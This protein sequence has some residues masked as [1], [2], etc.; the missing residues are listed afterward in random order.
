MRMSR[1][2]NYYCQRT[3]EHV[4]S[5]DGHPIDAFVAEALSK[6]MVTVEILLKWPSLNSPINVIIAT[7]LDIQLTKLTDNDTR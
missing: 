4:L 1:G 6:R 3:K 5:E 7:N 2:E